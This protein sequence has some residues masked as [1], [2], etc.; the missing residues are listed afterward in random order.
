MANVGKPEVFKPNLK[1]MMVG[2]GVTNWKYDTTPGY[3]ELANAHSFM[4]PN[5]YAQMKKL[6]CD[7][8]MIEFGGKV[9]D[10]C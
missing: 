5:D 2:N 7:Y 9:S 4:D 10:E 6:G 1:G 3:I 8:S